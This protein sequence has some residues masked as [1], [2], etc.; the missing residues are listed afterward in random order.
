MQKKSKANIM[1]KYIHFNCFSVLFVSTLNFI[2]WINSPSIFGIQLLFIG[3]S[4][5]ELKIGQ[6]TVQS[7][8]RF[9]RHIQIYSIYL[10]NVIIYCVILTSDSLSL[11][12]E[13]CLKRSTITPACE[14]SYTYIDGLPIHVCRS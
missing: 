7:L 1:D 8:V 11:C 12:N 2:K 4:R 10:Y 5:L 9:H 6:P 3:K 14:Q 13:N